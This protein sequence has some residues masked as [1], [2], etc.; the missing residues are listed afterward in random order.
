MAIPKNTYTISNLNSAS[1]SSLLVSATS[2]NSTHYLLVLS[3]ACVFTSG[4][5]CNL[6]DT[7]YSFTIVVTNNLYVLKTSSELSL[8]L[9]LGSELVSVQTSTSTPAYTPQSI[10]TTLSRSNRNAFQSTVATL[11]FANP[12]IST[13]S[14]IIFPQTSPSGTSALLGSFTSVGLSASQTLTYTQNSSNHILVNV[15]GLTG[16]TASILFN[17]IN[18]LLISQTAE[19]YSITLQD[20]NYVYFTGSI[21]PTD[22]ILPFSTGLTLQR[23]ITTVGSV[24]NLY[25][26]GQLPISL[27]SMNVVFN[28][29]NYPVSGQAFNISLGN[30]T[31]SNNVS[32]ASTASIIIRNSDY[33]AFSAFLPFTPSLTAQ[34]LTSL[35]SFSVPSTMNVSQNISATLSFSNVSFSYLSVKLPQFFKKIN[36]CCIDSS[37]SQTNILSCTTSTSFDRAI[38]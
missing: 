15:N 35:I 16:T 30:M 31:N 12:N 26:S 17:G 6:A 2:E 19:K 38:I 29:V 8:F 10:T 21:S 9:Q 3:T 22:T 33:L 1:L 28:S 7:Q 23:S 34:S 11:T 27:P 13:F 18:N 25:L 20:S 32:D 36:Y 5:V 37:C 14:L 4:S 24:T